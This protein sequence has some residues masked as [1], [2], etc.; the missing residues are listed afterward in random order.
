MFVK[1]LKRHVP[2]SLDRGVN[3]EKVEAAAVEFNIYDCLGCF[4]SP[5]V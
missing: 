2:K 5:V 3:E 4:V 1:L